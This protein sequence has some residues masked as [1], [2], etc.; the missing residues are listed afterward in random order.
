MGVR[1]LS[2]SERRVLVVDDYKSMRRIVRGLL[3][4]IGFTQVDEAADG[5]SALEKLRDGVF[6]FVISDLNM[7]PMSG[8]EFLR[9]LRADASLKATPVIVISAEGRRDV[10]VAAKAAGANSY[11]IKPFKAAI[12]KQKIDAIMAAV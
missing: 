9:E 4:H 10:I 7:A 12:L 8:L 3:A 2:G 6:S 5:A 11:I 1:T